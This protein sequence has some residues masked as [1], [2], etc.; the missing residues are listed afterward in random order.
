MKRVV[1]LQSDYLPWQGYFDLIHDADVCVLY[2]DVQYTRNDWRNRNQVYLQGRKAWLT[3]PVRRPPLGTAVQDVLIDNRTRWQAKHARTLR[4]GY[5]RAPYF[6][7]VSALLRPCIDDA[8]GAEPF[9]R[10]SRLNHALL[11]S[12]AGYLGL[13]PIWVDA[14]SLALEGRR[15]QR[16]V[17]AVQK[18]G[19][20][21]Y[22]S[23]PRGRDYLDAAAFEKVGV[24]LCYKDYSGYPPRLQDSPV[25]DPKVSIVDLLFQCGPSA[26][27]HIW[28]WRE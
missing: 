14:G 21:E 27:K 17:Q 4:Q 13:K 2:D 10:L 22:L 16:V 12:I 28:G 26:G 11:K 3:V 1:V 25:F 18:V 9:E 19:G 5:A 7:E 8:G 6:K 23:G 24:R 15:T 20:T